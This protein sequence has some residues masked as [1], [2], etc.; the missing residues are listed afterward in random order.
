MHTPH[1]MSGGRYPVL[2]ALAIMY[3]I[4]AALAVLSAIAGIIYIFARAPGTAL[5]HLIMSVG[6]LVA[7]F[8]LV[9]S[10]LA[11]AEVLKLFI[12]MEHNTRMMAAGQVDRA[13]AP[14]MITSGAEG[15][16]TARADNGAMGGGRRF[17]EMDEETAEGALLRGH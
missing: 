6:A 8:F 4:G 5:D 13:A 9:V 15:T 7:G 14:A 10:M 1:V 11:V 17:A 12:D 16:A 3:V 2:R